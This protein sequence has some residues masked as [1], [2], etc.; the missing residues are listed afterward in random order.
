MTIIAPDL[1]SLGRARPSV[2]TAPARHNATVPR[3]RSRWRT[4]ILVPLAV[5]LSTSGILAYAARDALHPSIR[6]RVA[7]VIPKPAAA[8]ASPTDANSTESRTVV[9][10]GLGPVLVQAP[11][12]VEPFPYAITIPAL[13]EGVVKDVLF[14]EGQHVDVG[15]IVV[16]MIDDDARLQLRAAEAAIAEREADIARAA[17]ALATA[18]AQVR[19]EQSAIAELKDDLDRKRA[20]VSTGAIGAAEFRQLEIRIGGMEAR[21]IT[22]ERAVDEARAAQRQA[23]AALSAAAVMRDE[24]QLRFDRMQVRAPASGVVLA[25]L[26]DPGTRISM[27]SRPGAGIDDAMSGAVLRLYDPEHLQVRVDVPLADAAKV[28]IGTRAQVTTEALPDTIFTGTIIRAVHEANVQRNTVQ[29]KIA[30]DE[31]SPVLKPEMLTRV[32]LYAV[33]GGMGGAG[34][35]PTSSA[36]SSTDA[37]SGSEG[38]QLL[39]P[40]AALVSAATADRRSVWLVDTSSGSPTA[41]LREITIEDSSDEGFALV[42]SGLRL[43]DRVVIDPPDSLRPGARLIVTSNTAGDTAHEGAHP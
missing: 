26:V 3:P 40:V 32:K 27:E 8:A 12:W 17:A 19:V 22:A 43:T 16:R 4:R 28:V 41:T 14:L 9:P 34:S 20:L 6:V 42:L 39:V 10:A 21:S 31:P 25:R 38:S 7:A 30:L 1:R 2:P 15:E 23:Q 35:S 5:L 29:F 18:E 13:A 36:S 11:G 24:A 37:Y 33:V